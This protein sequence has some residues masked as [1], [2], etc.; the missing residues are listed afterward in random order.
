MSLPALEIFAT[1]I[2]PPHRVLPPLHFRKPFFE[3]ELQH[4]RP[5][6]WT[7]YRSLLREAP[8]ETHR[9]AI[10]QRWRRP[11]TRYSTS[12]AATTARLVEEERWLEDYRRVNTVVC[13]GTAASADLEDAERTQGSLALAESRT[14]ITQLEDRVERLAEQRRLEEAIK[15]EHVSRK[16][17]RRRAYGFPLWGVWRSWSL[18]SPFDSPCSS[19]GLSSVQPSSTSTS[20][21]TCPYSAS[22]PPRTKPSL[23]ASFD[24]A[25]SSPPG[26]CIRP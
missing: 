9:Q 8:N 4:T 12:P 14:R 21:H 23:R 20:A 10:R 25:P 1:R 18:E 11:R 19:C 16:Q 15:L 13:T 2:R 3:L 7:L 24:S 6:K 5:V 22:S 26:S 17:S